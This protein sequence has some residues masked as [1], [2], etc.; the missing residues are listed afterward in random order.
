MARNSDAITAELR[1]RILGGEVAVGAKLPNERDLCAEFSVSRP[2][3]R[4]AIRTLE[5][6]GLVNVQIGPAGGIFVAAPN[7][8]R[9]A[10]ALEHLLVLQGPTTI[11]LEEFRLSFEP[12]TAYWAA[13][14]ATTDD[15]SVL[16]RLTQD[17]RREALKKRSSWERLVEID[18]AI[19]MRIA[20]ASRNYIRSAIMRA[21]YRATQE[22]ALRQGSRVD[23]EMR[24]K[25]ASELVELAEAVGRNDGEAA[26]RLM[27]S[28][29][30]R[31]A[32]ALERPNSNWSD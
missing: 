31:F 23:D 32:P 2:T 15:V 3:L 7:G 12:Q 22:F 4:E 10:D 26:R 28:H 6:A 1:R 14:R 8:D 25:A 17:H 16:H 5:A 30:R 11:E 18:M 27:E 24:A 21:I 29:I 19:H 9:I 20:H 13:V